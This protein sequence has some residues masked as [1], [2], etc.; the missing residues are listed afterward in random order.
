MVKDPFCGMQLDEK[1]PAKTS[2]YKG[3][4]YYFCCK[5]CKEKFDKESENYVQKT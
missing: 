5:A 3:E 1:S 4:T 2:S